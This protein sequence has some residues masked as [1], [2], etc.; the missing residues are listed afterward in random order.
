[1]R[2]TRARASVMHVHMRVSNERVAYTHMRAVVC[3]CGREI[4]LCMCV[5]MCIDRRI[6]RSVDACVLVVNLYPRC[7]CIQHT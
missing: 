7:I 2:S 3:I 1:M 6:Y 5:D 4:H